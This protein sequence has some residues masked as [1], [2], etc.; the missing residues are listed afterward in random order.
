VSRSYDVRAYRGPAHPAFV[1]FPLAGYVFA[2]AFDIV[3]AVAGAGHPWATQ[4]WHA[5]TFVLIA[6]L[7]ICVITMGTG[8][9]DLVRFWPRP[10]EEPGGEHARGDPLMMTAM[11]V[12]VMAAAFMIGAGDV[13]W[14]LSDYGS[15]AATPP[16]VVALSL[17]AAVVACAGGFFG[18]KLVF[19]HGI[20]VAERPTYAE[21]ASTADTQGTGTVR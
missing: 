17:A 6:G 11:H 2:A 21:A 14:R 5:G 1:H 19:R 4:L 12:S 10:T 9:W 13:A 20:G 16:G 18:G 3:S 8:F 15:R 7:A